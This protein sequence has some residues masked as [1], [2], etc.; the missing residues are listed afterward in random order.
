MRTCLV[1][2]MLF[3]VTS[4]GIGA[5]RMGPPVV[6]PPARGTSTFSLYPMPGSMPQS[7]QELCDRSLAFNEGLG[8]REGRISCK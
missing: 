8:N 6:F 2:A 1:V 4:A 5:Q 7:L 3:M